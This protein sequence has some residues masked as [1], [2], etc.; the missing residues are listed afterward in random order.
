VS[1][2]MLRFL[3]HIDL[4]FVQ[5]DRYGLFSICIFLHVVFQ[6]VPAGVGGWDSA[7]S[8]GREIR[9][10]GLWNPQTSLQLLLFMPQYLP[11]DSYFV[12]SAFLSHGHIL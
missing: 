1:D 6:G 3:T 8:Q 9:R 7:S 5:G 2:L 10:H 11:P 4:S 12:F